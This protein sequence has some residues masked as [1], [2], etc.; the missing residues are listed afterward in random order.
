MPYPHEH[1]A[2]QNDPS[3]YETFRRVSVDWTPSG[4]DVIFGVTPQG[5]TEIQSFRARADEIDLN[6]FKKWLAEHDFSTAQIEPASRAR[7]S[8]KN[9][10]R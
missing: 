1:T 2:R 8:L 3:K 10:T 4:V 7:E 5:K 6:K 9:A